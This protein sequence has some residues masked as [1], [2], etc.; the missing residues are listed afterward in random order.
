MTGFQRGTNLFFSLLY[1]KDSIVFS[2]LR[3]ENLLYD[4]KLL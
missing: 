1:E 2:P 4:N 3:F